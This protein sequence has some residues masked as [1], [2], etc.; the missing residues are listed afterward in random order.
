MHGDAP[1]YRAMLAERMKR[2]D[3]GKKISFEEAL[4]AHAELEAKGL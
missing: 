4:R 3:A 2:M 1:E